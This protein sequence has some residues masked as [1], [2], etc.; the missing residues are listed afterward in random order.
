MCFCHSLHHPSPQK[1]KLHAKNHVFHLTIIPTE[2]QNH[3]P[4]KVLQKVGELFGHTFTFKDYKVTQ[5]DTEI[6]HQNYRKFSTSHGMTRRMAHNSHHFSPLPVYQV[7]GAAWAATEAAG[8]T[9]SHLPA[10]TLAGCET[11]VG[12]HN[13]WD[14]IMS[15]WFA[16]VCSCLRVYGSSLRGR[17]R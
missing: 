4:C 9:P 5:G 13:R 3:R 6:Q 2:G 7:G 17:Q 14:S 15:K 11:S 12:N 1:N 16:G 10:T 8:E